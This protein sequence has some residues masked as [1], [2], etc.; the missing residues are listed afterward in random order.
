MFQ[1][2]HRDRHR[3]GAGKRSAHAAKEERGQQDDG[4]EPEDAPPSGRKPFHQEKCESAT[5]PQKDREKK[6][7]PVN[8]GKREKAMVGIAEGGVE[9]ISGKERD[10]EG[11]KARAL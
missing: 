9:K 4:Y 11:S 8:G 6:N 2:Q 1:P 3:R 5:Q 10:V 7:G